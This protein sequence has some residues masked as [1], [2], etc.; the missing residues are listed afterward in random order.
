VMVR[1]WVRVPLPASVTA[2]TPEY[3]RPR[4]TRLARTMV[5]SKGKGRG[6]CKGKGDVDSKC[7]SRY[8]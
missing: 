4:S 7:S 8:T 5:M 6:E 2:V 1:V 3:C